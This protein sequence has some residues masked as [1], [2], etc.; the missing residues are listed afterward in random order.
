[1]LEPELEKRFINLFRGLERAYGRYALDESTI[2]TDTGKLKGHGVT[3]R[4]DLNPDYY[5]RHL[6]GDRNMMLG[7]IPIQESGLVNF[8]AIDV[9]E[10]NSLDV[11]GI[12]AKLKR[13]ELPLCATRSKSGGLHLW[14]FFKDDGVPA[15]SAIQKLEKICDAL[16]FPGIEIFLKQNKIGPDDVGNWINLPWWNAEKT[17]RFGW[18]ENGKEQHDFTEWLTYAEGRSVTLKELNAWEVSQDKAQAERPFADGPPCL[19]AL[20]ERGIPE[21]MR[22]I[23]MFPMA[24]YARAAYGGGTETLQVLHAFNDLYFDPRMEDR[25]IERVAAS[26]T[27]ER[28]RYACQTD[29]L[30]S[31]CNRAACLRR[32]HGVRLN[33]EQHNWGTLWQI[34]PVTDDGKQIHS[35]CYWKLQLNYNDQ[36]IVIDIEHDEILNFRSIRQKVLAH[37]ILLPAMDN[38]DWGNI[39]DEKMRQ[40]EEVETPEVTSSVGILRNHIARF[41]S[42]YKGGEHRQEILAGKAWLS[43][44]DGMFWFQ[45]QFL[46]SFLMNNR[47]I[48]ISKAK[49]VESMK[50]NFDLQIVRTRIETKTNPVRVW[51]LPATLINFV[52]DV[53]TPDI[54]ETF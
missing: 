11:P 25:E 35:E 36:H 31:L 42:T 50:D 28:Y 33:G 5:S 1:M 46:V 24:V 51:K 17:E 44:E 38:N 54:R 15:K 2:A 30:K 49:L 32:K 6:I 23:T 47:F 8:A 53:R 37:R 22:N 7:V 43:P 26:V 27:G 3:V 40:V 19:Q 4:E 12:L 18:D 21:G 13:M 16:G 39:I 10:Y 45:G 14:A 29:P 48:E 20:A 34:L 41:L 9:D 52:T